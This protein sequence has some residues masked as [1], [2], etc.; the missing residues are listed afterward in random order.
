MPRSKKD[1]NQP[2]TKYKV[3]VRSDLWS[4]AAI[5][6]LAVSVYPKR[7]LQ[8]SP[9][10]AT[11]VR[12]IVNEWH[13]RIA[14]SVAAKAISAD[15][16]DKLLGCIPLASRAISDGPLVRKCGIRL[17]CPWCWGRRAG[18]SGR[19]W[20][21]SYF[22]AWQG[23][24]RQRNQLM[25]SWSCGSDSSLGPVMGSCR[26]LQR[27]AW[28]TGGKSLSV[29]LPFGPRKLVMRDIPAAGLFEFLSL[30][31]D[32]DAGGWTIAINRLYLLARG[33]RFRM[34][35]QSPCV[36]SRTVPTRIS[37]MRSVSRVLAYP[38]NLL[39]APSWLCLYIPDRLR[40]LSC[41]G[42]GRCLA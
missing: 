7:P 29:T 1:N 11:V 3:W 39:S 8:I 42:Q 16:G 2:S 28:C 37:L 35:T 9:Q 18:M 25:T 36:L 15:W 27:S 6:S 21:G 30:D 10:Y 32:A 38:A 14:A 12:D 23:N 24:T 13:P 34:W 41:V 4:R 22:P 33:A 40:G 31:P 26:H 5:R 20:T 17:L 19:S